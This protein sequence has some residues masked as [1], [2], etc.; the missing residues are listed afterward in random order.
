MDSKKLIWL[1]MFV[2]STI[3]NYIPLLWG[4]SSFSFASIILGTIGGVV[5]IWGGF[6]LGQMV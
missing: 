6:K 4:G 2:G 1:G 5:G 3:G